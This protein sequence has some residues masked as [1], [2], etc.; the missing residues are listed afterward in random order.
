MASTTT[1]TR[2]T[3]KLRTRP[4]F[5]RTLRKPSN[6]AS[7]PDL[8]SA[9]ASQPYTRPKTSA[10]SRKTSLA[11]LTN[12][13]LSSIPDASDNYA[14]SSVLTDSD[15]DIMVPVTP[16]RSSTEM[17]VGDF[18]DVPGGMQ[19]VIRFVGSVQGKG[20]VFAGVELNQEFA[21]RGKNNGDVDG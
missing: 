17:S 14:L 16:G 12:S 10:G 7:N 1:T 8:Y 18:V 15:S 5:T 4:S 11:A 20:G 6:T 13:S 21:S 19:G 3:N 2:T 9:Y